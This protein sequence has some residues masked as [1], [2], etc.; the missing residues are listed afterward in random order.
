MRPRV[1]PDYL[2]SG[3]QERLRWWAHRGLHAALFALPSLPELHS[4][5]Q[6][7]VAFIRTFQYL[8][9]AHVEGDY[10]E[11]G[12]YKG[13][14]FTVALDAASKAFGR[15]GSTMRFFAFDSFAGLPAPDQARDG[16]VFSSGDYA[17]SETV[18]WRNIR[19]A[20][21]GRQVIVVPGFFDQSLTPAVREAHALRA[22]AFVNIDCDIYPSAK[23]ALRFVTPIVQT[24]TVL[25]FDDWYF[26]GG[27]MRLGEPLACTEWLA[28]N[29]DLSLVDFG[30]VGTMGKLFLVNRT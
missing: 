15:P 13:Q 9:R 20:R 5:L 10:L 22:A 8:R 12:V 11:F 25:Y 17:A 7:A 19:S 18:F 2:V 24:G 30:E 29:P 23:A 28:D 16:T 4:T 26:S 6:K 21:R 3:V 27:N 1:G 14:G